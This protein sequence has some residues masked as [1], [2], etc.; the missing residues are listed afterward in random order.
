M[1]HLTFDQVGLLTRAILEESP[2]RKRDHLVAILLFTYRLSVDEVCNIQLAA[3]TGEVPPGLPISL[4]A[5]PPKAATKKPTKPAR[6][7]WSPIFAAVRTG[8]RHGVLESSIFFALR[9]SP[10]YARAR[11]G[12]YFGRTKRAR[13]GVL[14]NQSMRGQF[15]YAAP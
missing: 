1:K 5:H 8:A 11:E 13:P 6:T 10:L 14:T 12:S 4:Y 9:V 7:K 15:T 2:C 3:P